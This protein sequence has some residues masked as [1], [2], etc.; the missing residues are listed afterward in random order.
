M[1]ITNRS[2]CDRFFLTKVNKGRTMLEALK[3]L[4][5]YSLKL[6]QKEA[7]EILTD[8]PDSTGKCKNELSIIIDISQEDFKFKTVEVN[9]VSKTKA[10]KYLYRP[11]S[12]RGSDITPT[13]KITEPDKTYD[14]KLLGW[15]NEFNKTA[16]KDKTFSE[17]D[18]IFINKIEKLLK[19]QKDFILEEIQKQY[20]LIDTKTGAFYTLKFVN[21]DGQ[22]TYIG[23][24][25]IFKKILVEASKDKFATSKTHNASAIG[26]NQTCSVC[27]TQQTEVYGFVQPFKFYTVDKRGFISGGFQHSEAHKCFPV[28]LDCTLKM[29]EGKSFLKEISAT[30]KGYAFHGLN[31][32]IIPKLIDVKD[33]EYLVNKIN[34]L[35]SVNHGKVDELKRITNEEQEILFVLKDLDN[36]L[37]LNFMFYD[38]PKGESGEFKILLNVEGIL[39][40]RLNHLYKAKLIVDSK[41]VFHKARITKGK[42]L[43]DYRFTFG[44]LRTFYPSDPKDNGTSTKQK[45]FLEIINNIF[46]NKQ[47]NYEML[48]KD[49]MDTIRHKFKKGQSTKYYTYT[50]FLLL[51]FL[52]ELNLIKK[53]EENIMETVISKTE[54]NESLNK[55]QEKLDQF[56]NDHPKFFDTP[57]KKA[58]FIAGI[59]IQKLLI[60]QKLIRG[61]SPFKE[62]LKSLNIDK[63]SLQTIIKEAK[64]KIM[65]YENYRQY[66]GLRVNTNKLLN[67]FSSYMIETGDKWNLSKDEIGFYFVMGM[68]LSHIVSTGKEE[69]ETKSAMEQEE[70]E[71]VNDQ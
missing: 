46:I 29:E 31:Y 50:A 59:T 17:V 5:E 4:G 53:Q 9:P 69:Q 48:I 14:V 32:Y 60:L 19:E 67:I 57:V 36:F 55:I 23:D 24:Y 49:V 3:D 43:N 1:Y 30:P 40:S 18:K 68:N 58:I 61:S 34:K 27:R 11:G 47:I 41:S 70:G 6:N 8:Y 45:Q 63:Q 65:Q 20:K 7:L 13:S 39:P 33:L 51:Y 26:N 56:F 38:A 25:D 54:V 2:F 16:K 52:Y 37:S 28:C 44:A 66:S 10:A 71:E 64:A 15:F 42:V 22:E 21:A 12:P 62:K 35:K